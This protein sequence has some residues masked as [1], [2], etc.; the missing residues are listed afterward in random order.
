[1]SFNDCTK[2]LRHIAKRNDLEKVISLG[3]DLISVLEI[4]S[5]Y[6]F[7]G[8]RQRSEKP[9]SKIKEE[10]GEED[11]GN[12]GSLLRHEEWALIHRIY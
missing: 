2:T 11:H 5:S 7:R 9:P 10:E 12:C 8:I 3:D 4:E 1:M 6:Y